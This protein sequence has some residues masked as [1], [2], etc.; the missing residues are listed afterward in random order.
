MRLTPESENVTK[1]NAGNT[2][3]MGVE[4][5]QVE[6]D[7]NQS[8]QIDEG[9]MNV[10][11]FNDDLNLDAA[12]PALAPPQLNRREMLRLADLHLAQSDTVV[13]SFPRL[14]KLGVEREG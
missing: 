12:L 14:D 11:G 7:S 5:D 13:L 9:T 8:G 6:N 10:F 2:F 1:A 4:E 3:S